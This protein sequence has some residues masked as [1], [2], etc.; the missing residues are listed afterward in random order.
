VVLLVNAGRRDSLP[1]VE[2][3]LLR[4]RRRDGEELASV[5]LA[6]HLVSKVLRRRDGEAP[7]PL[8]ALLPD[9]DRRLAFLLLPLLPPTPD[10]ETTGDKGSNT[11][12]GSLSY[13]VEVLGASAMVG[14][15]QS[16]TTTNRTTEQPNN[17][18]QMKGKERKG[19]K[20]R[21]QMTKTLS[22]S[23]SLLLYHHHCHCRCCCCGCSWL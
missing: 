23:L 8:V 4:D 17:N 10:V 9:V 18:N 14:K 22:H 12:S 3:L 7:L 21:P 5:S 13:D 11:P 1:R 20:R 15:Q 19:I 2:A 16:T 6:L